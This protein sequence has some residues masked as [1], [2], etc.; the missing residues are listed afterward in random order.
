VGVADTA[1][2]S[3]GG[4]VGEEEREE[5]EEKV[6]GPC[7]CKC[8]AHPRYAALSGI[9]EDPYL[10]AWAHYHV[11]EEQEAALELLFL[12]RLVQLLS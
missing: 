5:E 9:Q 12:A 11:D 4:V 8:V 3:G 2:G 10:L 7:L 6:V 1:G